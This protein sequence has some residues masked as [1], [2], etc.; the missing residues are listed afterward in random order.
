[1][2]DHP[3][4]EIDEDPLFDPAYFPV[5]AFLLAT[6]TVSFPHGNRGAFPFGNEYPLDDGG[7]LR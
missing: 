5:H 7:I 3:C 4:N 1:M 6:S 2:I